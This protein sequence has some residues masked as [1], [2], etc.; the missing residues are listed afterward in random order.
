MA[1]D[2]S[3]WKLDNTSE[4]KYENR[5]IYELLSAGEYVENISKLWSCVKI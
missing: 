2:L 4:N 5:E 3:F 1:R